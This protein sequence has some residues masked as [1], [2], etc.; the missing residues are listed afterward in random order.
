MGLSAIVVLV[1][2]SLLLCVV[3]SLLIFKI[4][5]KDLGCVEQLLGCMCMIV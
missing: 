5:V 2:M 3:V 4:W 1:C